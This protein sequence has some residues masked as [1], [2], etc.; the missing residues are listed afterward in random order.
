MQNT[1]KPGFRLNAKLDIHVYKLRK[2]PWRH[3]CEKKPLG[4]KE[5]PSRDFFPQEIWP[6]NFNHPVARRHGS[7]LYTGSRSQRKINHLE[8]STLRSFKLPGCPWMAGR[9]AS[10]FVLIKTK[11][12][13][14][15]RFHFPK[16]GRMHW[17]VFLSASHVRPRVD[18][19]HNDWKVL[20][21]ASHRTW[22]S[23]SSLL[24]TAISCAQDGW[25][26]FMA[27]CLMPCSHHH[28][29]RHYSPIL[30]LAYLF[31][32]TRINL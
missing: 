23:A 4:S 30:L 19:F 12:T 8:T 1:L 18:N 31:L 22:A 5:L 28:H 7:L 32:P 13:P 15:I 27:P 17:G 20:N 2:S 3:G 11:Q 9:A 25:S 16:T 14:E 29:H 6:K 10:R 21:F 26:V 24:A